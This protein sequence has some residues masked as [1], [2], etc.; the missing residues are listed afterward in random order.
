MTI[1]VIDFSG[2][3]KT[4]SYYLDMVF[5]SSEKKGSPLINSFAPI[6]TV[7]DSLYQISKC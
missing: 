5:I 6:Q 7:G 1:V 2:T 3:Q 4:I